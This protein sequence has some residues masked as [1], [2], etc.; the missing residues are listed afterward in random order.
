MREGRR[1]REPSGCSCLPEMHP[2]GFR[3]LLSSLIPLPSSLIAFRSSG[4]VQITLIGELHPAAVGRC[5]TMADA[6]GRHG[7]LVHVARG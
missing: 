5:L 1:K 3:F 6:L 4:S 2:E 7:D